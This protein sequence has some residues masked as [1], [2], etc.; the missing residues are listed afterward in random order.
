[1]G[2]SASPDT[3]DSLSDDDSDAP[4]HP[5]LEELEEE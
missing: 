2:A 4:S 3:G 5:S 1:L